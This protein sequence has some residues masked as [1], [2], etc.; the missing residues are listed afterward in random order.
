MI[1]LSDLLALHTG[2]DIPIPQLQMVIHQP[3]I[4]EISFL[5]TDE[6]FYSVLN[7][8]TIKKEKY[9]DSNSPMFDSITNYQIFQNIL[10]DAENSEL[11]NHVF[12][13]L[14]IL[15][16]NFKA[17]FSPSGGLMLVNA[18]QKI[19]KIIDDSNFMHLQDVIATIFKLDSSLSGKH[20]EL[21]PQDKRAKEIADKI[22]RARTRVAAQKTNQESM[23][24]KYISILSVGLH[25]DPFVIRKWTIP[26][27]YEQ[28]ERYQLKLSWDIDLRVR[29]AGGDPKEQAK[30]F[31]IDI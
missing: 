28:M 15:F 20:Q 23:L 25:L 30:D 9:F 18:E 13:L 10:Q 14:T 12:S 24:G 17:M 4:E 22:M 1:E 19:T 26:V 3:S 31:M 29:L 21:N 7:I 8:M 11:S 5:Q 27:L 2:V 16:P 6:N